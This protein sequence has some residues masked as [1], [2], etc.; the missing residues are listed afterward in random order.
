MVTRS[1]RQDIELRFLGAANT[2]TGSC[3][4]IRAPGG[5]MIIDCGL[6]QGPKALQAL[7]FAA[8][9]VDAVELDA[10]ILTH[11]HIDHVGLFPRLVTS[12]FHRR[13]YATPA[14][15][16]LLRWV[17]TDAGAIQES[18]AERLNRRNAKRGQAPVTALYTR[19][20]AE[21]SLARLA[22]TPLE[23]WFEPMH[24][25][26]ARLH[27][28]GHILGSSWVELEFS[29]AIGERPLRMAVSGDLGPRNKTLSHDPAPPSAT[30]VLVIEGTYGDRE[31]S[32]SDEQTRRADL[33]REVRD[34]L[35]AG[36]NLLIPA[37]AVE[38]SQELIHDLLVLVRRHEIPSV[39]IFL[40]SP[41]AHR[42][43]EVFQRHA[44][45]LELDGAQGDAFSGPQLHVVET[46][47]QSKAIGRIRGGAIVIAG[48]G[49][50]DAGRIKHHLK[51]HLWRPDST[52]LFVG[53]Q[54]PGTLGHLIR[55]G[56]ERVRIHGEEVAVRA[57]IRTLDGYSGHADRRDLL[58]W[59]EPAIASAGAVF[60]VHGEK[61]ALTTLGDD[62]V[63]RGLTR[64]RVFQPELDDRFAIQRG[65]GGV[66]VR[67]LETPAGG[68]RSDVELRRALARG[69][70]WHNDYA[71]A[72]LALRRTLV[73]AR[74]DDSRR[75]ILDRVAAA[76][77]PEQR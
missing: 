51:D 72:V 69:R 62:L 29:G 8:F 30:D 12:G 49:M 35:Q 26:R 11:A 74:D 57:R 50:C 38:R 52:V 68:G 48:S 9:P 17:L 16:D 33:A 66:V 39:P 60:V 36:G 13:A 41:L 5:S 59:A 20:D 6:F 18:E 47:D 3:L 31:R 77:R 44:R 28:A 65:D 76:L 73:D 37:F 34:A 21:H 42:A 45:E 7:N 53:Y 46:V 2:V 27:N 70:D 56:T 67:R 43:T 23:A 58:A 71:A 1:V 64:E 54:V 14:T 22:P 55:N 24:G 4:Y 61:D 63:A 75:T 32:P 10:V 40:D 15:C 25:V 19:A